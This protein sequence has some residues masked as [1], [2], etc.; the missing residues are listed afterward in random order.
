MQITASPLSMLLLTTNQKAIARLLSPY[1][2]QLFFPGSRIDIFIS[3]G[4]WLTAL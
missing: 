1:I 2:Q 4:K 3:S